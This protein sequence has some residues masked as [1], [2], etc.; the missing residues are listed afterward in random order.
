MLNPVSL[1]TCTV[2][3]FGLVGSMQMW[4]ET[5]SQHSVLMGAIVT[6][7]YPLASL[8]CGWE[9]TATG[10]EDVKSHLLD[11]QLKYKEGKARHS[12]KQGD[13]T[14]DYR[15]DNRRF[16]LSTHDCQVPTTTLQNLELEQQIRI[17]G[18]D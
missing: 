8:S 14:I 10:T 9:F 18:A 13:K 3:F 6:W 16:C 1:L 2:P 7:N 4:S 11:Q 17:F 5:F 12:L 15:G